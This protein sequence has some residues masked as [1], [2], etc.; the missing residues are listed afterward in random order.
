MTCIRLL[1][2]KRRSRLKEIIY[3]KELVPRMRSRPRQ[4]ARFSINT[5]G[6]SSFWPAFSKLQSSLV[7][8]AVSQFVRK[9]GGELSLQL[10]QLADFVLAWTIS[11][12]WFGLSDQLLFGALSLE[13][14][15]LPFVWLSSLR[16]ASEMILCQG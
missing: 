10:L 6:Q 3:T 12:L 7:C 9:S 2:S 16:F 11:W 8:T 5:G 14:G 13:K 4:S 1:V 15:V